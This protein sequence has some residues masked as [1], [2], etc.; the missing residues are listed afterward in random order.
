[1]KDLR[2]LF[3][4]IDG[5][6][7]KQFGMATN[8][9]V[10][11]IQGDFVDINLVKYLVRLINNAKNRGIFIKVVGCSSWFSSHRPEKNTV[12][13]D[14]IRAETGLIIED[15]VNDTGGWIGRCEAVLDY[16]VEHNP[17][18]WCVVDDGN[19]YFSQNHIDHEFFKTKPYYDI[20]L[21]FVHTHGR[22]GMNNSDIEK[23]LQIL[24]AIETRYASSLNSLRVQ[25]DFENF[26]KNG[27]LPNV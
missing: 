7:N 2:L 15:V 24:G 23:T 11:T 20:R 6:F 26:I 3:V 1:M 9:N 16:V 18:Y 5:V 27:T 22:Y 4:D 12:L 10:G 8:V 19:Y 13:F 17:A 14:R 21:N 25:L